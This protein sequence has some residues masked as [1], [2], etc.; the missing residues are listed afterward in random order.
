[1]CGEKFYDDK[2]DISYLAKITHIIIVCFFFLSSVGNLILAIL[3][4]MYTACSFV[5]CYSFGN[6]L[7]IS[8]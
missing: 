4:E 6:K 5:K 1:M 2:M 7:S 8:L 3:K